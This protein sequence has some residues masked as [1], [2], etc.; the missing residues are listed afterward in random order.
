MVCVSKYDHAVE[1]FPS[2]LPISLFRVKDLG[3]RTTDIALEMTSFDP[4]SGSRPRFGIAM[5][6]RGVH[7]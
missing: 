7:H 4:D 6:R 2:D 3:W 1:T 5:K